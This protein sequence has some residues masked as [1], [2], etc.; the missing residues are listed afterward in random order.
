[1]WSILVVCNI[2]QIDRHQDQ[3][4]RG[5]R[6]VRSWEDCIGVEEVVGAWQDIKRTRTG[7]VG[8]CVERLSK[9]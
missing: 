8:Q 2:S 1:M 4:D 7:I 9:T 3:K 6:Y 5:L